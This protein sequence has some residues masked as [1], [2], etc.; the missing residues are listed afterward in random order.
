[1]K[2]VLS[3]LKS[4][5]MCNLVMSLSKHLPLGLEES[6]TITLRFNPEIVV[7]ILVLINWSYNIDKSISNLASFNTIYIECG[8]CGYESH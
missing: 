5:L 4:R 7:L 2:I 6:A 8:D 3:A 1:M